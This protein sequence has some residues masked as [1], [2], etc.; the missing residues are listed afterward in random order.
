[1]KI[2]GLS[3]TNGSGKDTVADLLAQ[4][5]G[6]LAVSATE[7]LAAELTVRGLPLDRS[8]K[9]K[10]SAEWRREHGMAVIVDRAYGAYMAHPDRYKGLV[11]GSLRHPAEADRIHELGGIMLWV[12]ADPKVRYGRITGADRGRGAEDSK[13]YEHWLAD[14][15]REMSP[16]GDKATLDM[17]G[18]RERADIVCVNNDNDIDAFRRQIEQLLGL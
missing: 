5:H 6:W 13:P 18:V 1:M 10:L 17:G 14:E 11:V 8:Q 12:D 4:K 3:G 16:E 9:S 15:E 7:M 2:I